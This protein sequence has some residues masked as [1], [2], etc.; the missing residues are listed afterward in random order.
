MT[1][2]QPTHTTHITHTWGEVQL[3]RVAWDSYVSSRT[4]VARK[5]SNNRFIIP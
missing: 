3:W 2:A 5:T 1:W 4:F